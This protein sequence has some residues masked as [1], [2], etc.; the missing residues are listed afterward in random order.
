MATDSQ[1]DRIAR[2]LRNDILNGRYRAGDRLPSE[3]EL[4]QRFA[5]HRGPVREALRK[6]EQ[7]GLAEIRPGGVRVCPLETASLDIVGHL[8]ELS[9]P[10]DAQM[11]RMV[12]EV[13]G[14]ILALAGRLGAERGSEEDIAH[15]LEN[16]ERLAQPDLS[17]T[18]EHEYFLELAD[19]LVN[20]SDNLVLALAYRGIRL[21]FLERLRDPEQLLRTSA[22]VRLTMVAKLA[23]ALMDRNGATVAELLS[24]LAAQVGQNAIQILETQNREKQLRTGESS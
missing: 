12:L 23:Q 18:D 1:T 8:L 10:P 16:L 22:E 24:N 21:Q 19:T 9:D 20:A 7:L 13:S 17:A 5:V 6:V 2:D 14:S 3:R 4:A 15:C 11:V